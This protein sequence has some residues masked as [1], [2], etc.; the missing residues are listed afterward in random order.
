MQSSIPRYAPSGAFNTLVFGYALGGLVGAA[1]L[2]WLY[3]LLLDVIPFV[4]VSI[5]LTC[6]FGIALGFMG[7]L[8]IKMGHCRNRAVAVVLALVVGGGGLAASYGWAYR[9]AL[10]EL[11]EQ[12]SGAT[13]S[14][15]AEE[16]GL[17]TW[18][19]ARIDNG[20]EVRRSSISGLGVITIWAIE[21]LIVLGMSVLV[22]ASAAADPYCER[23]RAWTDPQSTDLR[24]LGAEHVAPLLERGDLAG[25]LSLTE[26]PDGDASTRIQL[27]RNYCEKCPDTAY[28][29][30]TEVRVEVK[31]GKEQEH[32][33]EL[34][35]NAELSP[36]LNALYVEHF[37]RPVN[38]LAPVA[39][40]PG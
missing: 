32:K 34:L 36:K 27:V 29:T 7:G 6:G 15:L 8:V 4:Y 16:V 39:G 25:V 1:A 13:V 33:K 9:R 2:A 22:M 3:A 21:A 24:G 35:E 12:S 5:L 17:G 10:G 31:N 37:G 23:C 20:W 14:E 11:A 40:A 26:R 28:L 38:P 18:L 19:E 30:V